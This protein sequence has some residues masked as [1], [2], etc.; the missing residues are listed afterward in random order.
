M[1]SLAFSI[2]PYKSEAKRHAHGPLVPRRNPAD[3]IFPTCCL[4]KG[5]ASARF[6]WGQA[7][8]IELLSCSFSLHLYLGPRAQKKP[9]L[10]NHF[11]PLSKAGKRANSF[12]ETR[13]RGVVPRF[14]MV[15]PL[16]GFCGFQSHCCLCRSSLLVKPSSACQLGILEYWMDTLQGLGWG[17]GSRRAR[18]WT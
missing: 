15:N 2:L 18:W 13:F 9:L 17:F 7:D 4:P 8:V 5:G 3:T 14:R 10:P 6:F 16:N 12:V 11:W 1:N